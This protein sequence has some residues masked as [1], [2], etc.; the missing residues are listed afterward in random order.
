MSAS[1][2][3]QSALNATSVLLIIVLGFYLRLGMVN[4][5]QLPTP[6]RNDAVE[7]YSY[8]VNLK[9]FGV[10]SGVFPKRVAGVSA[11][12]APDKKRAPGYP[13]FLSL[14]VKFPPDM[15][16]VRTIQLFQAM[17]G[18]AT[19]LLTFLVFRSVAPFLPSL[20]AAFLTAISPH[21]IAMNIYLLTET[22][23][24]FFL[25]LYLFITV[26][27]LFTERLPYLFLSGCLLAASMLIRPTMT[28]FIVFFIVYLW[29]TFPKEKFIKFFPVVLMGF[30]LV[31]GPWAIR[32][33]SV[34]SPDNA[35]PQ[36]LKSMKSGSYPEL[37]VKGDPSTRGMQHRA[38]PN[39][40]KIDSYDGFFEDVMQKT[41]E[42]PGKYLSWYLFGK[43]KTYL[44][45]DIIA[46]MGDVYVYQIRYSPFFNLPPYPSIHALM[47]FLHPGIVVA[48]LAMAALTFLPAVRQISSDRSK[49][50]RRFLGVVCFYFILVH[51]AANPLPRYSIPLRPI[52]Y[53]LAAI[54]IWE[55]CQGCI[56]RIK[57]DGVASTGDAG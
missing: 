8:A 23:F 13:L 7:Y 52:L 1:G 57:T 33:A 10:Y 3:L 9:Y 54:F 5:T 45:W 25:C 20:A 24:T 12:P 21:L 34:P 41:L 22:L 29:F 42:E 14:F 19:V 36:A 40:I 39:Y 48:A 32:N 4:H 6:I 26:R 47:K 38:D 17:L 2:T 28:Y 49:I 55:L 46:G 56:R 31:Q 27:G 51:M 44:S 30:V 11:K 43:P 18:S 15:D 16:M 53:G 50:A 35:M 37:M